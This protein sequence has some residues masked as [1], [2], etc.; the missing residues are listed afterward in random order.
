[1]ENQS[2]ESNLPHFDFR[3]VRP[4][5]AVNY[6]YVVVNNN[7]RLRKIKVNKVLYLKAYSQQ[8]AMCESI[9]FRVR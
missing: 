6:E 1:M 2:P 8:M 5:N 4:N 9:I 7:R 3:S